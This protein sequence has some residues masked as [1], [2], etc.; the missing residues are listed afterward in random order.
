MS[1]ARRTEDSFF[2]ALMG[3]GVPMLVAA[4]AAVIFAGGFA[5]FLA[6]TGEFLPQDVHYLGMSAR[7][8]RDVCDVVNCRV[9][10]FMVH[11]RAAFGGAVVGIGTLYL[12]LVL[13]PLRRGEA[14][15]WWLLVTSG[16][17]GFGSFLAYLRYGYL[18][19]WHGIGTLL[20]LPVYVGGLIRSRRL[21][22][23]LGWPR[24]LSQIGAPLDSRSVAGLG[25]IA[26]MAGSL[27]TFLGGAS[28]LFVGLT[29]VFVDTDLEYMRMSERDLDGISPRLVPLIAH[30]RTGFG[31]AVLVLGLTTFLCLW[32]SQVERS[33]RQAITVAGVLSIMAALGVH[34]VVGYTTFRHTL[35]AMV[36]ATSLVVGLVLWQ[37]PRERSSHG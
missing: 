5:I 28:I 36:A 12:W 7:E 9:V 1:D 24:A 21:I 35:P 16:V 3:D 27:G 15:A 34:F 20:L 19:T 6:A 11:D 33:L 23:E 22:A 4:A 30:D 31:G 37:V 2:A 29:G 13:F 25:R 26:L 14:W 18:D 32:C 10:E 8:L 17:L